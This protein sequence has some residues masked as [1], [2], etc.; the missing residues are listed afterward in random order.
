MTNT[1]D[2]DHGHKLALM[3]P[4]QGSQTV[5]MLAQL[6]AAFPVVGE[7]FATASAALD[8]DLW[9]VVS[10][11]P[12]EQLN[13]TAVTQPALL[14][15]GMACWRVWQSLDGTRPDYFAGHSL[16]EYTALCAAGSIDF[17]VAV[18][19]VAERGRLMQAAA[20]EG[21]GKMAAIIGL[22][23]VAVVNICHQA[24]VEGTISAANFN[25]PGQVV[26]AGAVQAVDRAMQ[27][28]K[29]AGA[30]RALPLAVSVP[31]H[32]ALMRPAAEQLGFSI[33]QMKFVQPIVPVV[34]NVDAEVHTDPTDIAELLIEQLYK[35]VRW[36]QSINWLLDQGVRRFVECGPG[37]VLGGLV[38][39]I[40]KEHTVG[41]DAIHIVRLDDPQQLQALLG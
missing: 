28:C 15:A 1:I 12:A 33:R 7:T 39:R 31:S 19:L 21:A 41:A 27:L 8:Y 23:D 32:C 35:P 14:A 10:D 40:A 4:G 5:G 22:E 30:K 34:H 37:N 36:T 17:D 6:A 26:I 24:A 25:S 3:F 9:K 38:K 11:G 13:D 2:H 18:K 16:G 20:P 29:D